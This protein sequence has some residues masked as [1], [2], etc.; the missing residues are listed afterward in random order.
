MQQRL[1]LISHAP[2]TQHVCPAEPATHCCGRCE[3]WRS[4]RYLGSARGTRAQ[5]NLSA[6]R[7]LSPARSCSFAQ[8]RSTD[9]SAEC[10]SA[11]GCVLGI[12][13][14]PALARYSRSITARARCCRG[15]RILVTRRRR[16]GS[17]ALGPGRVLDGCCAERRD[18]PRRCAGAPLP[19]A[20]QACAACACL[21]PLLERRDALAG[22]PARPGA[23][24][25]PPSP[26]RR[27]TGRAAACHGAV[28]VIGTARQCR[29]RLAGRAAQGTAQ[30]RRPATSAISAA[31]CPLGPG[32]VTNG[33]AGTQRDKH[34]GLVSRR[35]ASCGSTQPDL[36]LGPASRT[37]A[38][39]SPYSPRALLSGPRSKPKG[40]RA[41]SSFVCSYHCLAECTGC[42]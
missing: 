33:R 6:A 41:L 22:A 34:S 14:A 2:L 10:S 9:L 32:T 16:E 26:A 24:S 3:A 37:H 28:A 13:G 11:T 19:S 39:L 38:R 8:G 7:R 35:V 5:T 25:G 30:R 21:A 40:P 17:P 15:P 31:S 1:P 12:S 20:E 29:R 23:S 18:W 27:P 42:A 4:T 36:H